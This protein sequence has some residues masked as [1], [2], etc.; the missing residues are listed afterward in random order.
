MTKKASVYTRSGDNGSTGLVSGARV[1]KGDERIDLYGDV[2]ELMSH[3]GVVTANLET[4]EKYKSFP[5]IVEQLQTIQSL[6]F[7]LGSNLACEVEN[8]A[9]YKLPQVEQVHIDFLE[10]KM[11]D[12]DTALPKM[13]FFILPG[14]D[15]CAAHLHVCRTVCRRIERSMVRFDEDH[16]NDLPKFGTMFLNRLSDYF[17]I[18]SRYLNIKL[19]VKEVPWKPVKS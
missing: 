17:F 3:M 7:D 8:R 12:M 5:D 10:K 4:N 9:K 13:N 1:S 15:V 18:V 6:L 19:N 2:D 16:K 14:G 11:D